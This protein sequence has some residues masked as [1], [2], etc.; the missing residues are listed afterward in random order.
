MFAEGESFA[1]LTRS[2]A[3]Y[4]QAGS[5]RELAQAVTRPT[6][7]G[8]PDPRFAMCL[9][10]DNTDLLAP[11][12]STG[13][14][15]ELAFGAV[16]TRCYRD[17]YGAHL[18][19]LVQHDPVGERRFADRSMFT[20][21]LGSWLPA[22]IGRYD[23]GACTDPA[24][25]LAGLGGYLIDLGR[26]PATEF[27]DYVRHTVWESM[28]AL[29]SQLA[30]RLDGPVPDFWATDARGFIATARRQALTPVTE[31]YAAEGGRD[32]LQ[33]SLVRYGEVLC[34]WPRLVAA[35]RQLRAAG[36]RL[37]EPV[38]SDSRPTGR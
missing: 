26:L 4:R 35:A 3:D 38:T 20:I 2:E 5:S 29:V 21:G 22:C 16:L 31:L 12:P 1:R 6:I 25:R 19:W 30:E 24:G 18:P 23:P 32:G 27:D 9:G 11:F 14:A 28:S 33:H 8:H 10:L 17:G 13:R 36:R 37:A 34:W 15:E 7:T